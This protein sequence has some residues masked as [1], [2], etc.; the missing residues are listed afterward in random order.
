[1]THSE[2]PREEQQKEG[3]VGGEEKQIS[4]RI[5]IQTNCVNFK[6]HVVVNAANVQDAKNAESVSTKGWMRRVAKSM[7]RWYAG[8]MHN[9]M[10]LRGG[11]GR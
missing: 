9:K 8:L 1:M 7:V 11:G 10:R 4:K 2:R 5:K 3:R 6:P